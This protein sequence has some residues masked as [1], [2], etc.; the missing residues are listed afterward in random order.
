LK[1]LH[2]VSSL[3]PSGG[4][5]PEG[6]RQFAQAI[7]HI[8]AHTVEV[9]TLDAPAKPWERGFPAEVHS[10]GPAYLK[11]RYAPRF[12]PWLAA[13]AARYD[14]V[15]VNGLWQYHSFATWRVMQRIGRPYFVFTHGM[16]DPWFNRRYPLK[17]LKKWLY[18]PWG[19]YR[20]LRDAAGVLFTCEEEQRLARQ[21]FSLYRDVP[22]T[23]GYGIESPRG[24]PA[25]ET[26]AFRRAFPELEGSRLLLFLSRIHPKK[27]CDLL[28]DAFADAASA[29]ASLR[30]MIAGPDQRGTKLRLQARAHRLGIGERVLWPGMLSGELKWGALRSADAFALISHQENFGIAV[31]EALAC[32]TPVI[33]SDQVNIWREIA[34]HDAGMVCSD[35][36][37]GAVRALRNWAAQTRYAR[38][39]ASERAKACYEA[40][41]HI[42]AAAAR[43]LEVVSGAA[44]LAG[45]G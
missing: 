11:Y 13:N 18:W 37:E 12:S 27:G 31:V 5:P 34:G 1:I 41:F 14:A 25:R 8:D 15:I 7:R 20:V 39:L 6:I 29:D 38:A 36:Q 17:R 23:V 26:A 22:F 35:T 40:H 21:S 2:V 24:D 32:G 30:L 33:I 9:A 43:L 4:G 28:L 19:E 44:A 42:E 16:L 10:L 45:R 3:D